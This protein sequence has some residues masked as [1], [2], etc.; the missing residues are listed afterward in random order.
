MAKAVE[1][2]WQRAA[3]PDH[4]CNKLKKGKMEQLEGKRKG[5]SRIQHR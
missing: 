3:P 2:W 4:N 1:P 5:S